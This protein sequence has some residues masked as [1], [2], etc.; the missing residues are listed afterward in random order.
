MGRG[1]AA[2]LCLAALAALLAAAAYGAPKPRLYVAHV[3][4][5]G[6]AEKP[7]G[8]PGG[9]GSVSICID[10]ATSSISFGFD[11]LFLPEAPT[12]G[13]IHRGAPG[14]AGPV[15]FPFEKPGPIDINV[16]DVQWL[17]TAKAGKTAIA[18]LIASP[19]KYYVNVHTKKFPGGA[20]RGQLGPWKRLTADDP[21]AA[22]CGAP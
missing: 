9:T 16:G 17:G 3:E 22:A 12:A 15:V 10:P 7:R 19:T 2:A 21:A 14:V 8:Q 1:L 13:H 11:A 6:K 4:L 20:V 18:G 5:T